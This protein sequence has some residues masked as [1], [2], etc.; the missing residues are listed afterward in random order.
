MEFGSSVPPAAMDASLQMRR[1]MIPLPTRRSVEEDLSPLALRDPNRRF[2]QAMLE[3][4]P[5]NR[6]DPTELRD[7][8][9]PVDPSKRGPENG[10][11]SPWSPEAANG[12]RKEELRSLS[13][14]TEFGW[15]AR[16]QS[17]RSID[18]GWTGRSSSSDREKRADR[19]PFDLTGN[20]SREANQSYQPSSPFEIYS[21][22]PK[23]KPT[24]QQLERRATFER[25]LNPSA[26]PLVNKGPGSL[27][28]VGSVPLLPPTLGVAARP[29]TPPEDPTVAYNRQQER[30]K[31]PVFEDGYK[32]YAPKAAPA[33]APAPTATSFQT[34]LN[35]QPIAHDFPTRRF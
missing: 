8:S 17:R 18:S 5:F 26:D 10:M 33:P 1:Q 3:R 6:P 22:R 29:N 12:R 13:P 27:E 16:D 4:D 21:P 30:W 23:E 28:P 9:R 14:I 15:E 20:S 19:S 34:P 7:P 25:L 11:S 2:E 31:G 32:K 24:A 35:R